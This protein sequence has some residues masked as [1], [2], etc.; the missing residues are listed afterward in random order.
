MAFEL[1]NSESKYQGRVFSV[2]QDEVRMPDGHPVKLDVVDHRGSVTMVP[3]DESGQVW[4]IRQYRHPAQQELL[5][6][7]AGVMEPEEGA[8]ASAAR[9]LREEIGMGARHLKPLGEFFLAPGYSTEYM[10]VFLA[11]GLY[12]AP[13]AQDED[14][15]IQVEKIPAG[16]ALRLAKSGQIQ[17][18]KTIAAL[19]LASPLFPDA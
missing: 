10:H 3:L 11:T 17:D 9:E 6:L 13:L 14:E 5:E 12:P 7:P 19:F 16:E 1:I 8:L 18:A 2:R 4:F 15:I